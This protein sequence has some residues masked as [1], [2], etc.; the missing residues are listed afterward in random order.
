LTS[1]IGQKALSATAALVNED[2][3]TAL[4]N[5]QKVQTAQSKIQQVTLKERLSKV[6]SVDV[7]PH[8]TDQTAFLVDVVVANASGKPIS[9]SIVF[10]VPGVVALMG[11]NGRTLGLETTGLT[12]EQSRLFGLPTTRI[13]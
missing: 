1:R 10:S 13:N 2:V 6:L 8:E 5:M 12:P 3:R 4:A 7:L 11:S 9:L